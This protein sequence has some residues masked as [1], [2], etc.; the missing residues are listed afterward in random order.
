MTTQEMPTVNPDTLDATTA[1]DS[2]ILRDLYAKVIQLESL[3]GQLMTAAGSNPMLK[4][5]LG[6]R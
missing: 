6:I 4:Q 5:L 1:T 2:E 3:F